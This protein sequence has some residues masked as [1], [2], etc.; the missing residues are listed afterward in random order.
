M[1]NLR[2]ALKGAAIA[3]ALSGTAIWMTDV[4]NA[5]DGYYGNDPYAGQYDGQNGYY[6][7]EPY[8][9]YYGD[10]YDN[11]RHEYDGYDNRGYGYGRD[12][13]I[14]GFSIQLGNVA[15]GYRDGYWDN[16]HRWHHWRNNSDYR[17]YRD[18]GNH[19]YGWN[20]DRDDDNGWQR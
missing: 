10:R 8:S 4:A 5:H 7:N 12:S 13:G 19:Y 16:S 14:S 3:M 1:T 20:H 2:R 11:G 6:S 9:G 15:F 17:Y 18:H